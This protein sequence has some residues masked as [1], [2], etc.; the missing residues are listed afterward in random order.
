MI[1]I[2]FKDLQGKISKD[3]LEKN[4]LLGNGLNLSIP[5]MGDR[6]DYKSIIPFTEIDFLIKELKSKL[7]AYIVQDTS[8]F[9]LEKILDIIDDARNRITDKF[10]DNFV[11][12]H[13]NYQSFIPY[14]KGLSSFI[15]QNEFLNI[16]TLNYDLLLYWTILYNNENDYKFQEYMDGFWYGRLRPKNEWSS[17][18]EKRR[19]S[20]GNS[21][22]PN[23]FYLHGSIFLFK[24]KNYRPRKIIKSN[25][26]IKRKLKEYIQECIDE[27]N[28]PLIVLEG[29]STTK[30]DKIENDKKFRQYGEFCKEQLKEIK[31]LLLIF[32]CS[33]EQDEHI[34]SYIN[35]NQ[36]LQKIYITFTSEGTK[37]KIQAKIATF[38]GFKSKVAWVKI[39]PSR[40][41]IWELS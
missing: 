32:G 35:E 30:K 33:F 24:G 26:N 13:E 11:D 23:I 17:I 14:I 27:H 16:F 18:T 37:A 10:I 22:N 25:K 19:S 6:F 4:L 5:E 34:L 20:S 28:I 1:E 38:V 21:F 2:L 3:K 8:N 9:D 15:N 36:G 41:N 40:D 31:G 39:D 12:K 7:D 29:N